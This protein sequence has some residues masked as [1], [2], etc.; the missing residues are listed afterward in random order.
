MTYQI[1]IKIQEQ[2]EIE[3]LYFGVMYY[4]FPFLDCVKIRLH[5]NLIVDLHIILTKSQL[6]TISIYW[7]K[8]HWNVFIVFLVHA[9]LIEEML[10]F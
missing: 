7:E 6:I 5:L 4:N 10:I 9:F 1:Q 3:K 8:I 2:A